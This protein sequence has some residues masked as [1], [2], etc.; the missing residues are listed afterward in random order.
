MN[1]IP[2]VAMLIEPTQISIFLGLATAWSLWLMFE[3]EPL[4]VLAAHFLLHAAVDYSLLRLTQACA[5][6][7]SAISTSTVCTRITSCRMHMPILLFLLVNACSCQC[8]IIC[9]F[10]NSI[11]CTHVRWR[12]ERSAAVRAARVRGRVGDAAA[13]GAARVLRGATEPAPH[14]M[15]PPQVPPAVGRA[16][17]TRAGARARHVL[18]LPGVNSATGYATVNVALAVR[19]LLVLNA[20][21]REC[22]ASRH[23]P[24]ISLC[25]SPF[26][27]LSLSSPSLSRLLLC[28]FFLVFPPESSLLCGLVSSS[29]LL[30]AWRVAPPTPDLDGPRPAD[31]PITCNNLINY[32]DNWTSVFPP[33]R[34]LPCICCLYT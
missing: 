27:S 12:T 26:P 19:V 21:L 6:D 3:L 18:F 17:H 8:F 1:L 23:L 29:S 14:Q 4:L 32:H 33:V 31:L 7:S 20:Q 13:G 2:V 15:G 24:C 10:C 22:S 16:G 25:S 5:H 30:P 11:F 9:L 28:P 34:A